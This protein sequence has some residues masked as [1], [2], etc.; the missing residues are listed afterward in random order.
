M[1]GMF[2]KKLMTKLI[3]FWQVL[4]NISSVYFYGRRSEMP[5]PRT[6]IDLPIFQHKLFKYMFNQ[7]QTLII[8]E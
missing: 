8:I 6:E 2:T 5:I 4:K 7:L 1:I 3:F